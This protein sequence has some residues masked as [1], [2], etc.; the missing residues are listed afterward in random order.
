MKKQVIIFTALILG[1]L[2]NLNS[3]TV[4]VS[5]DAS[6]TTG[7]SSAMLDV[8]STSKG[9]LMPRVSDTTAVAS[10][11]A[12]LMI[13][14]TTNKKVWMYYN[15]KWNTYLSSGNS[16]GG[17]TISSNGT[18]TLNGEATT[19]N[20]LVVNPSTARNSGGSTPDWSLFVP[21][22]I[23]TWSFANSAVNEVMF[24]VQMPH[25]YREG[26]DIFPHVHWASTT[27]A[28][29]NR[30]KWVLDYQWVNFSDNFSSSSSSSAYGHE[31]AENN[32]ISLTAYQ[33]T[34][35]PMNANGAV[36]TGIPG[37]GKKVSSILTCRLYRDGNNTTEDTFT[38][39]AALLSVDFHYQIDSFGS[40][41]Q[42]T[43]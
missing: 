35:T 16:T 32:A 17:I 29:S 38:G 19:W 18:F 4:V 24:T 1:S 15:N 26:T 5:D 43:K 34:I 20:D 42:Y 10:P 31:L 39:N 21:I 36:R 8:K 2:A 33:S 40:D 9:F 7:A 37:T 11:T 30:V 6:Y 12:G 41:N 14:D 25:N 3:Q 27:A 28:G 13:Y 22:N 23:F